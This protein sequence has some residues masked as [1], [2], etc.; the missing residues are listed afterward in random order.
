MCVSFFLPSVTSSDGNN[1][2]PQEHPGVY[3]WYCWSGRSGLGGVGSVAAE[4][5]MRYGICKVS[6]QRY[7]NKVTILICPIALYSNNVMK[8]YVYI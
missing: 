4:M 1:Q 7:W 5:L 3:S 2:Q 6:E 8:C